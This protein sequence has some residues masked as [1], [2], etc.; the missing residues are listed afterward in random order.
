MDKKRKAEF[1]EEFGVYEA[2]VEMGYEKVYQKLADLGYKDEELEASIEIS[3]FNM[4]GA[5]SGETD[6]WTVMSRANFAY[7][8]CEKFEPLDSCIDEFNYEDIREMG[9]ELTKEWRKKVTGDTERI[10][11][12]IEEWGLGYVPYSGM[13]ENWEEAGHVCPFEYCIETFP[14]NKDSEI[15]C[16]TFGH[17][18]PGK[19]EIER[20]GIHCNEIIE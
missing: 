7:E 3:I 9:I 13:Y 6:I 15:S 5:I 11:A 14:L 18:C 10:E 16:S 1:A 4:L 8:L 12:D 2:F 19:V 17:A 20:K